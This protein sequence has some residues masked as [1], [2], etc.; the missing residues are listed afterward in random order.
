MS[1]PQSI[2][3]HPTFYERKE[4]RHKHFDKYI[5]GWRPQTCTACAGSGYYDHNG[6]PACGGCDGTGVDYIRP[7]YEK[8]QTDVTALV[9]K[10]LVFELDQETVYRLGLHVPGK[11][12]IKAYVRTPR[13]VIYQYENLD[14]HTC[15]PRIRAR[16]TY[17]ENL[18]D[19]VYDW[20]FTDQSGN[21]YYMHQF[22]VVKAAKPRKKKLKKTT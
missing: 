1:Q 4:E 13:Q 6:S 3:H 5:K 10:T 11:M 17:E 7:P 22:V 19:N 14:D 12:R 2:V 20:S 15:E 21:P 18:I 9:G 16:L 8:Q